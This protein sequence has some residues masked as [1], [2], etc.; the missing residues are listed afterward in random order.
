M[1][2]ILTILLAL[3]INLVNAQG[4]VG[5]LECNNSRQVDS[6][7]RAPKYKWQGNSYQ[8][9]LDYCTL[10]KRYASAKRKTPKIEIISSNSTLQRV[11]LDFNMLDYKRYSK[12]LAQFVAK[13]FKSIKTEKDDRNN[14]EYYKSE[15]YPHITIRTAEHG[16]SP[17]KISD[18]GLWIDLLWDNIPVPVSY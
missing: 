10:N 13:E 6:V 8:K 16:G 7:L 5:L 2:G 11:R 1:K 9:G 15:A 14:Y 3:I 17:M 18:M 4:L 12:I